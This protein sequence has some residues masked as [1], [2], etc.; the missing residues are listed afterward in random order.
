MA[1]EPI[2]ILVETNAAI[3]ADQVK[4]L[5]DSL[6]AA[7]GAA[8]A[9]AGAS[10]SASGAID[11]V[12]TAVGGAEGGT[13]AA[14]DATNAYAD[15]LIRVAGGAASAKDSTQYLSRNI[16]KSGEAADVAAKQHSGLSSILGL[17]TGVGGVAGYYAA[18]AS[19]AER[20]AAALSRYAKGIGLFTAAVTYFGVKA[21]SNWEY[22]MNR[23][24]T[25]AGV[26]REKLPKLS[27]QLLQSSVQNATN[28]SDVAAAAYTIAS[29]GFNHGSDTNALTR[30]SEK[31]GWVGN[32]TAQSSAQAL[33]T[34]LRGYNLAGNETNSNSIGNEIIAAEAHGRMTMSNLNPVLGTV[35]PPAAALGL[36]APQVLGML[37]TMT[38]G[39]LS[40]QLAA[41][42]I[43]Q[44][45]VT[46]TRPTQPMLAQWGQL[47]L[48]Q[49]HVMNMTKEQGLPATLQYIN[50]AV[51]KHMGKDGDVFLGTYKKSASASQD[52][53]A[54]LKAANPEARAAM[55]QYMSGDLKYSQFR[56]EFIGTGASKAQ[57]D[58]FAS[59]YNQMN[60]FSDLV[61]R[62]G[63]AFQTFFGALTAAYGNKSTAMAALLTT[64]SHYGT[65]LY[66]TQ[67]IAEAGKNNKEIEGMNSVRKTEKFQLSEAQQSAKAAMQAFGKSVW[68]IIGPVVR[69]GTSFLGWLA[70]TPAAINGLAVAAVAATVAM[71]GT[72]IAIKSFKAAKAFA[73]G[74][75]SA[76]AWAKDLASNKSGKSL[77]SRLIGRGVKDLEKAPEELLK[78]GIGGD[79]AAVMMRAAELMMVAAE[80]MNGGSSSDPFKNLGKKAEKDLVKDGEKG[81]EKE[82]EKG[83]FGKIKGTVLGKLGALVPGASKLKGL[84]GLGGD[85]G[86]VA[87][88]GEAAAGVG[89]AAS[90]GGELA[91]LGATEAAVNTIPVAGQIAGA[92]IAIGAA[93]TLL[94]QHW[95]PFQ[96]GVNKVGHGIKTVAMG[97]VH[98][99]EKIV[100]T[101]W[102]LGVS[103]VH[104]VENLGKGILNAE[105][106]AAKFAWHLGVE[107]VRAA[108]HLGH[109]ILNLGA[110]MASATSHA[111]SSVASWATHTAANIAK[112][113]G[114][115][116]SNLLTGA[117]NFVSGGVNA[118]GNFLGSFW[119]DS[120][121]P[122]NLGSSGSNNWLEKI[123]HH[124][125]ETANLLRLNGVGGAGSKS[126]AMVQ[127]LAKIVQLS[128]TSSVNGT[129][130]GTEMGMRVAMA[131]ALPAMAAASHN[132][133]T[134]VYNIGTIII[135]DQ[136]ISNVKHLTAALRKNAR[137]N[138][139][140]G[141]GLR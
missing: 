48:D 98:M 6:D 13:V 70:K 88:G 112:T 52:L 80:K 25:S 53:N 46:M 67:A 12:S 40:A 136:Q 107:G 124:T 38:Q 72:A 61:K 140:N 47:G 51:M 7:A 96:D 94:Y 73:G 114:R 101:A 68:G 85:A 116:A 20:T 123:A 29:S 43:R 111:L 63:P 24:V 138:G 18:H 71:G 126:S 2:E 31:L 41:Q 125:Y 99:D 141:G 90:I 137:V 86:E 129:Q 100:K 76:F 54:M 87:A 117:G 83:I 84:I 35:I 36:S 5:A 104:G 26:A 65:T 42:Y 132:Q 56:R 95:K 4:A 133:P 57:F 92:V 122:Q 9:L 106:H 45:A 37:S 21:S 110:N 97:V 30:V 78:G 128:Y 39:G 89:E 139:G 130:L 14:T 1:I 105:V 113:A 82:A 131:A 127:E 118:V 77:F 120:G 17:N 75:K 19:G 50:E 64:G 22:S 15:S 134:E 62:G 3:A 115:T 74:A 91:G 102:H 109:N 81:L 32:T 58:Q 16:L 8:D 28:Q 23:L 103:A 34:I 93:G 108:E 119:G 79:S 33:S 66:N 121:K 11:S 49:G 135:A 60:G 44:T 10:K 59:L 69:A 27:Q 55:E